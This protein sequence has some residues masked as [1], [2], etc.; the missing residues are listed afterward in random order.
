M[1]SS[2]SFTQQQYGTVRIVI[3]SSSSSDKNKNKKNH[4]CE[5]ELERF[6]D[7][8]DTI[9]PFYRI[10]LTGE[11]LAAWVVNNYHHNSSSSSEGQGGVCR[12]KRLII[13]ASAHPTMA[14]LRRATRKDVGLMYYYVEAVSVTVVCAGKERVVTFELDMDEEEDFI[15]FVTDL[16][17]PC[18]NPPLLETKPV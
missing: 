5:L 6:V 8:D 4:Y 11:H 9:L 13:S 17:L 18:D 7:S 2:S 15:H 16:L 1:T 10:P 12:C 3:S 14:S